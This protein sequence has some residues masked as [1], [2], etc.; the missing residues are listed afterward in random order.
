MKVLK[1]SAEEKVLLQRYVQNLNQQE[2]RLATLDL[3][4]DDLDSQ[5]R[6]LNAEL[7]LMIQSITFDDDI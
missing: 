1:G 2:D 4:I 7:E 5:S 3:E 6:K